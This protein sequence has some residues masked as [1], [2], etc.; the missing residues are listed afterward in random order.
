M[1]IYNS[2]NKQKE[3]FVPIEPGKVKMYV[4]GPTVYNFFHI[5]NARVFL[6]FDAFRSYLEYRGYEVTMVQNFTDVDDKIIKKANDESVAFDVISERYIDAYFNDADRLG[7]KRANYHPKVSDNIRE[8]IEFIKVLEEKGHAYVID[9][10]V[11]FSVDSFTGYGK[12]SKQVVESLEM[13]A[14]IDVCDEKKNPYDFVLWKRK[15]DN[16]PYWESPWGLGRPGWHIEC[17]VM[18]TSIL[19]ET[20]DIHAGGQD[21]IFPHHENEIAQSEAKTGKHYVNYWMHNGY[22]NVDNKKMSKSLNNFFT[23]REILEQFD[24]EVVRFFILSAHYRSPINFSEVLLE[25]SKNGLERLYNV[26]NNVLFLIENATNSELTEVE[27]RIYQNFESYKDQFIRAMDDDFN[28]AD[29]IAAIFELAKNINSSLSDLSSKA[30][31]Q[32]TLG[33]YLE[34]TGVIGLL[35]KDESVLDEEIDALIEERQ[36]ARKNKDFKKSDEIRDALKSKGIILED[37]AQGVKWR[38]E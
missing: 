33:L 28:T 37:T 2:L 34:I 12:L 25:A 19:G 36:I 35:K 14:R 11:Y 4:C 26:K 5:G 1:K 21:L 31:L 10:S 8:I 16:E 22:I 30:L 7:I 27:K 38:R 24:A 13:G 20:I 18:S 9:G 29:G 23:T 6:I 32:K 17:S 15:K 3:T